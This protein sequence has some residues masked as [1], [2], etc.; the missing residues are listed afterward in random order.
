MLDQYLTGLLPRQCKLITKYYDKVKN[1]NLKF[2]IVKR[3]IGIILILK[4]QDEEVNIDKDD[5]KIKDLLT[6]N[7]LKET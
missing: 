7:E 2:E 4:F 5:P 6:E 3:I 1:I